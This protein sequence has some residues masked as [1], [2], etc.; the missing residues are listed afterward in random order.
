M[1][2]KKIIPAQKVFLP[3]F[4]KVLSTKKHDVIYSSFKLLTNK[5][6]HRPMLLPLKY[7]MDKYA[8]L[9]VYNENGSSF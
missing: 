1:S 7:R 2:Y 5:L 9:K 6:K 4:S 3:F 8:Y